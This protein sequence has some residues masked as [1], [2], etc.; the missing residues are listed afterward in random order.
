MIELTNEIDRLR[1]ENKKLRDA[2]E[3]MIN[4]PG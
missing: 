2:L 3:D 4:L 1:A